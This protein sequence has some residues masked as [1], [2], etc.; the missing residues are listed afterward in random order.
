MVTMKARPT[1]PIATT[2]SA[3]VG[4]TANTMVNTATALMPIVVRRL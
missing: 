2:P 4:T 1:P 3:K